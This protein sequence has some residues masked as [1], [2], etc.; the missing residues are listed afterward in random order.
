MKNSITFFFI[1]FGL[2]A[3][4]QSWC[5]P[6]AN[7]K[8]NFMTFGIEGYT[9]INYVGDTL[10]A[11]QQAQ[12]LDKHTFAYNY[13]SL[14]LEDFN[15]GM[16][17]TYEDNGVVYVRFENA[18]D[19]LYNFNAGIGDSWKIPKRPY[20]TNCALENYFTVIATGIKTINT[21]PLKYLVLDA[22]PGDIFTDTIVEKIGFI[23]SYLYPVNFCDSV[24]DLSEGDAFRCYSDDN[25][26]TYK[27]HYSEVCDFIVNIDELQHPDNLKIIP[28]PSSNIFSIEGIENES[29]LF[30]LKN[31]SGKFI[32]TGKLNQAIDVSDLPDGFYIISIST[33]QGQ[34]SL[35]FVKE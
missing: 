28:N 16:D 14:Q 4:S 29:G 22:S 25:F 9:E 3:L 18:W 17:I 13:I 20:T 23:N 33:D 12:K 26:L 11:G 5:D 32:R 34:R 7:W 2:S 31:A 35:R 21:I 15:Q 6:G 27:P 30:E 24:T 1:L 10:I 8:Y 19:T